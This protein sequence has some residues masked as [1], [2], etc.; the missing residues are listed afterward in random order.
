MLLVLVC[1]ALA[2]HSL[3]TGDHKQAAHAITSAAL[4]RSATLYVGGKAM[5]LDATNEAG[6]RDVSC[7]NDPHLSFSITCEGSTGHW[8]NLIGSCSENQ[9]SSQHV[10]PV[11]AST[12]SDAQFI[13]SGALAPLMFSSSLDQ[14]TNNVQLNNDPQAHH[15]D[16]VPAI[17]ASP[18]LE[19][20][21]KQ[22]TVLNSE[23]LKN[24]DKLL[25]GVMTA[26]KHVEARQAIRA[27]WAKFLDP[28][29]HDHNENLAKAM[30]IKFFVGETSN[31]SLEATL[32]EEK[33]VV[34]LSGFVESYANLSAKTLGIISWAH[35]HGYSHVMK[36]DDD[37]FLQ[38]DLLMD[39]MRMTD[40]LDNTYAGEFIY[41]AE[42][43]STPSSKWYMSDQYNK[44]RFPPYAFGSCY[45]VGRAA[46]RHIAEHRQS[47]KLYRVED[48]GL[49]LWMQDTG[50]LALPATLENMYFQAECWDAFAI[51][52]TPIN[53]QEMRTL[54]TNK[55]QSGNICGFNNQFVPEEC[56]VRRC[57]CYPT[58]EG[59]QN[60]D[61]DFAIKPYEDLIPRL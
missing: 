2:V 41:D 35:D 50:L 9:S 4:C 12:N 38:L 51:F 56:I 6:A 26:P 57:R 22:E 16:T 54:Q 61:T 19:P 10:A 7:P 5:V 36:V 11:A 30:D 33:G 29:S 3:P 39:W 18:T 43:V 40:N 27:T 15:E 32:N 20:S 45:F 24:K 25:I 34:R 23:L 28:S 49:A 37:V 58:L 59:T 55:E 13:S 1:L 53:A 21:S 17:A 44:P 52:V 47:L 14:S 48:A 42:V 31:Q 8:L 46:V 60:C